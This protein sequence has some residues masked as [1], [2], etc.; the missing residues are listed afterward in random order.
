MST[1]HTISLIKKIEEENQ[2]N[3][4]VIVLENG[5]IR[6]EGHDIGK[7]VESF[8]GE[9][10]SEYEYFLT[11]KNEDKTC[12]FFLYLKNPLIRVYFSVTL[13]LKNG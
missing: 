9:G 1:S 7:N 10:H 5:D 3:L 4:R 8:F 12:F 11:I 13:M 6:F 2:E